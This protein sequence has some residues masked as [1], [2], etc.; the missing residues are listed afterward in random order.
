MF[1][2][3]LRQRLAES[4]TDFWA[5]NILFLKTETTNGVTTCRLIA[6]NS[7]EFGVLRIRQ[8]LPDILTESQAEKL[9]FDKSAQANPRAAFEAIGE[10]TTGSLL[11][12]LGYVLRKGDSAGDKWYQIKRENGE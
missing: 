1:R 5:T 10:A 8:I 4:V 3:A 11:L 9:L 7:G 2:A 12:A 6:H